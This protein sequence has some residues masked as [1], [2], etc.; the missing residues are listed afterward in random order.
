MKVVKTVV[1]EL[2]DQQ[3]TATVTVEMPDL[4]SDCHLDPRMVLQAVAANQ[5]ITYASRH[6]RDR[7]IRCIVQPDLVTVQ[8]ASVQRNL[9]LVA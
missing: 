5:N 3:L 4:P 6:H 8:R 7:N 1:I 9:R 2:G